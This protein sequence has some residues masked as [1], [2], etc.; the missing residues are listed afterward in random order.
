MSKFTVPK[1]T[2]IVCLLGL[3]IFSLI[4]FTSK[5][6]NST[7][8]YSSRTHGVID[9]PDDTAFNGLFSSPGFYG[10]MTY[11][12]YK[13]MDDSF[14]IAKSERD[15]ENKSRFSKIISLGAIGVHTNIKRK[16]SDTNTAPDHQ[17]SHYFAL[18]GY[19]HDE[20]VHF[21]MEN[22][23]FNLAYVKWHA[24][25]KGHYERK[26]I[27]VRFSQERGSVLFPL[28]K[29]QYRWISGL[30]YALV[31]LYVFI[32]IFCFLGLPA[33]VL[34]NISRGKPFEPR[35]I[36]YL[37]IMSL[38]LFLQ[39]I[40]SLIS[41]YV[42]HLFFRNRIPPEFELKPFLPL[43]FNNTYQ[44]VAALAILLIAKAFQRGYKLQQEQDL[45]I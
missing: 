18:N 31:L 20:N 23:A 4:L 32:A 35:N 44:V 25:N 33:Q 37:R 36:G 24:P 2:I 6:S 41:P 3:F 43:L 5:E 10:L 28:T 13:R 26:A 22:G 40:L 45:T 12:E 11:E 15:I 29:S 16:L 34:I 1:E 9:M 21:F 14:N 17:Y 7:T 19:T 39:V 42:L 38:A 8:L 30:V 27:P